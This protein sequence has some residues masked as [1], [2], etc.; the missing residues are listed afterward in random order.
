MAEKNIFKV[1]KFIYKTH[2]LPP[3]CL[4]LTAPYE[5]NIVNNPGT[6]R[7]L[8]GK[9]VEP[10]RSRRCDRGRTLHQATVS[11]KWDGKAQA[12]G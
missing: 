4:K 6:L 5:H 3:G 8:M 2:L 12:V 1:I 9:T 10:S 11:L 7:G